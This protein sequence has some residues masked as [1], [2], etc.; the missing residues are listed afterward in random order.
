VK[1]AKRRGRRRQAA[2]GENVSKQRRRSTENSVS[3]ARHKC[4]LSS[5]VRIWCVVAGYNISPPI[6]KSETVV[7]GE[8]E[9][10]M[11]FTNNDGVGG[12]LSL[13]IPVEAYLKLNLKDY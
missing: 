9:D 4:L 13:A 5:C 10:E 1:R 11:A 7:S 2:K 3:R 8:A 6:E 12:S